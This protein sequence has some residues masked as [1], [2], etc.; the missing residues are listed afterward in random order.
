MG[1]YTR[2]QTPMSIHQ[3]FQQSVCDAYR[4]SGSVPMAGE[5]Q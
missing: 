4:A 3:I 5:G 2:F 1:Y